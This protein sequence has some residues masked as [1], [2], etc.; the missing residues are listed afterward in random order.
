[1]PHRAVFLGLLVVGVLAACG[2]ANTD[3]VPPDDDLDDPR[4]RPEA[5]AP[6]S[7]SS[8]S[9]RPG[10]SSSGNQGGSS[11]SSSGEPA[12]AG[13]SDCDPSWAL[14]AVE[15]VGGLPENIVSLS[16]TGDELTAY[17]S[18]DG[19]LYAASRG[20][21]GDTFGNAVELPPIINNGVRVTYL[22]ITDDALSL[23]FT[24]FDGSVS[25]VYYT[26]R[27]VAGA[28]FGEPQLL[29]DAALH[30]FPARDGSSRFW[31]RNNP[32]TTTF[33]LRP[34]DAP[35]EQA[36]QVDRGV[37]NWYEPAS[38]T[39]WYR[40]LD[41]VNDQLVP[42]TFATRWD[43]NAWGAPVLSEVDVEF[44]SLDACRLYGKVGTS[45]VMRSR[46]P[47]P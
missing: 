15:P 25:R 44:T 39:L 16:I 27:A 32:A 18:L 12:D 3:V 30:D 40:R 10:G 14:T 37:P 24:R 33:A 20:G 23:Y 35:E 6:S 46:V 13:S 28:A 8:S 31:A 45:V 38:S 34:V 22:H 41:I 17:Y 11:S 29:R 7:S 19:K 43:G 5:G 2:G 36:R 1:M 26:Y 42:K 9:G 47:P 21:L 4:V